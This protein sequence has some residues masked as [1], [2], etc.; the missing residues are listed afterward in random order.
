MTEAECAI[1][2]YD[3]CGRPR[4]VT[5]KGDRIPIAEAKRLSAKRL[6]IVAAKAQR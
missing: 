3:D 4:R 5:R 6:V 2:E 1:V